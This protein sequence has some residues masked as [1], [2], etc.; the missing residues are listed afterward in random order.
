MIVNNKE[1]NKDDNVFYIDH[2]GQVFEAVIDN[3]EDR[4]GSHYADLKISKDGK[5]VTGVPHNT[6]P[7]KHSWKHPMDADERAI[8]TD[9]RFYGGK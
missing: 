4:D 8:H 5:S 7:E 6:S 9:P 2:D 1:T 3:V